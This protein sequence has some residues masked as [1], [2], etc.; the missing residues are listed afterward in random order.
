MYYV[1]IIYM[2]TNICER[3]PMATAGLSESS[4]KNM[5]KKYIRSNIIIHIIV[6]IS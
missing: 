1:G 3:L 4:N 5:K 6:I 2:K